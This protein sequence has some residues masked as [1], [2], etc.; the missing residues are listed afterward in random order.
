VTGILLNCRR[1][2]KQVYSS[3][4][5]DGLC[6]DCR[7]DEAVADL[8]VEH[9]RL[10]RKR[11]RYRANGANAESIG[12]QIARLEDRMASRIVGLVPEEKAALAQLKR[13]LEKARS[14]RYDIRSIR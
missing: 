9:L 6:L 3:E 2:G 5:R 12:R 10:W 13:T 14:S 4:V 1:C 8:R 11:E 7:V